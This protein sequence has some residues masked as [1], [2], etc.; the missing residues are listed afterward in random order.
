M[1]N[2]N[3][4]SLTVII[5]FIIILQSCDKIEP[6]FIEGT[7]TPP[8]TSGN[9]TDII[10]LQDIKGTASDFKVTDNWL[11]DSSALTAAWTITPTGA[12]ADGA[13]TFTWHGVSTTLNISSASGII[14]FSGPVSI[15]VGGFYGTLSFKYDAS[16]TSSGSGAGY[17]AAYVLN[18]Q[19]ILIED[20]TGHTCGN[21]PPA[22]EKINE[23]KG[24]YG[25]RVLSMAVHAGF[26]ADTFPAMAGMYNYDFR[27]Q[28]GNELNA[29]FIGSAG[30]PNGL[31]NRITYN[32]NIVASWGSWAGHVS[33]IVVQDMFPVA[34][35]KIE[36]TYSASDSTLNIIVKTCFFNDLQ[37][38]Y[39]MCAFLL[40]DSVQN[41]QKYYFH[42]PENIP[43]YWHREVLRGSANGTWG[44]VL[45]PSVSGTIIEKNYSMTVKNEFRAAYC[46]VLA[47]IY[48]DATKG[49]VQ[50]KEAPIIQ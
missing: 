41:W 10:N 42:N 28:V 34:G 44:E 43:D 40:E 37:G 3:L 26:Y 21:C 17:V 46:K 12:G 19:N 22:A 24:I 48:D 25:D 8:P 45:S 2:K 11:S 30:Y 20:Y 39:K 50:V 16:L 36:N 31:V 14:T 6:P 1:K 7:V 23:L 13:I 5:G 49:I 4:I 18:D 27:T 38:T 15:T 9:S 33:D 32:G 47:F 35:I 29:Y